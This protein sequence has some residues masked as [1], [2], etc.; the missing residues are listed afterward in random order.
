MTEEQFGRFRG[1]LD[2]EDKGNN[3]NGQDVM[4]KNV[5]VGKH[6]NIS[7]TLIGME[8]NLAK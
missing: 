3:Q 1:W 2:R 4:Y 8:D 5:N 6:R 7:K